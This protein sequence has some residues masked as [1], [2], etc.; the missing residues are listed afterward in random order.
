MPAPHF[1]FSFYL[2]SVSKFLFY[3]RTISFCA[4]CILYSAKQ[5]LRNEQIFSRSTNMSHGVS[6]HSVQIQQG[7]K[8]T[9]QRK[10]SAVWLYKWKSL[11]LTRDAEVFLGVNDSSAGLWEMSMIWTHGNGWVG[12]GNE[13][14][15][16][17]VY[18][19]ERTESAYKQTETLRCICKDQCSVQPS[20]TLYK[21]SLQ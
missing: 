17:R 2:W 20:S 4:A 18:K 3:S 21:L 16:N 13:R 1:K 9:Y 5:N 8:V 12:E 19:M 15:D 14:R 6:V 7:K 10:I 11:F